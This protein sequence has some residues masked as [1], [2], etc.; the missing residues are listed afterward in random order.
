MHALGYVAP[1]NM[2]REH[3]C[4]CVKETLLTTLGTVTFVCYLCYSISIIYV[5]FLKIHNRIMKYN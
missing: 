4:I 2:F 3:V 5:N 1:D